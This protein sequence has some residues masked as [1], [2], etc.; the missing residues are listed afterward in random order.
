MAYPKNQSSFA[1]KNLGQNFL[2]SMEIR[3]GILAAAGEISERKILEV[4]PGLGFLT[5]GLLAAGAQ[6]TAI[7]LDDR[8][9]PLLQKKFAP[10]KEAGQF[11]LYHGSILDFD[12]DEAFGSD[13]YSCI[14]NIPYHITGPILRRLLAETVN[15]PEF[16]LL[17]VQKEVAQKICPVN[18]PK[19]GIKRSILS[20]SVELFAEAEICFLVDRTN[21][22]PAP[23]VDSAIIKLTKRPAALIAKEHE[24]NFFT[25]VNA[26]FH[27]RRK[28]LKNSLQ[29]FFGKRMDDLM[30]G[31]DPSVRAENLDISDW[32]RMAKVFGANK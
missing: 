2:N 16:S 9:I 10:Q 20:L 18:K 17:M 15:R 19:K 14:A 11:E 6:V 13:S 5:E 1:K 31:L 8:V 7:D 21:F 12:L 3:D 23:K 26:G 30:E 4:G 27:E 24:A 32:V 28:K 25:I 22:D 29:S